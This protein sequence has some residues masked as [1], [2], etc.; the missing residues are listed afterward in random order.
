MSN[1]KTLFIFC[2]VYSVLLFF[3]SN[4]VEFQNSKIRILFVSH[5]YWMA[6]I[7]LIYELFINFLMIFVTVIIWE[8]IFKGS[9]FIN[10]N[11]KK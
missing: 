11:N 3:F 8:K 9:F 10:K 2:I 5:D 1:K 7:R 6:A 4:L